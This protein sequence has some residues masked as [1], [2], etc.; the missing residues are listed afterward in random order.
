MYVRSSLESTTTRYLEKTSITNNWAVKQFKLH[1]EWIPGSQNL[2]ADS[3]SRLLDVTPNAQQPDEAK[4]HEFGSYCFEE[5]EPV[6]VLET[7]TTEV[8]ELQTVSSEGVECS[9]ESW[10]SPVVEGVVINYGQKPRDRRP[11]AV[12]SEYS[13]SSQNSRIPGEIGVFDF[14]Y[15]ERSLKKRSLLNGTESQR[16]FPKFADTKTDRKL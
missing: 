9:L 16:I 1:L 7:V 5:L 15:E 13:E 2:L 6:K 14:K 8:I 4:D 11:Q 12:G 10:D 3:L